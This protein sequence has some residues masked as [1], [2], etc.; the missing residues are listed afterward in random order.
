MDA[1]V[2][3]VT[4]KEVGTPP[5]DALTDLLDAAPDEPDAP[6]EPDAGPNRPE[7]E[8]DDGAPDRDGSADGSDAADGPRT[9]DH[10]QPFTSISMV[11]GLHAGAGTFDSAARLS[12]DELTV[13][14]TSTRS[15]AY[16]IWT[17]TRAS[18]TDDFLPP[19]RLSE[20]SSGTLDFNP[21]VTADGSTMYFESAR[22]GAFGIHTAKR[23]TPD[24][25]WTDQTVFAPLIHTTYG[26]GQPY[27][28]PQDDIIYFQ[29]NRTGPLRIYRVSR[30]LSGEWDT[31]ATVRASTDFEFSPVVSGDDLTLYFASDR[32]GMQ[33]AGDYDIWISTRRYPGVP[34]TEAK[35]VEGVN[36]ALGETPSWISPDGCRLYFARRIGNGND[37]R[38]YM[39]TR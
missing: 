33:A 8:P 24:G 36:T 10:A 31:P 4:A 2:D 6:I 9:C 27:V 19:T 7:V 16:E 1:P 26:D 30:S 5:T 37:S 13:Y 21:S 14:F 15:G 18:R 38:I 17:A 25:G 22:T 34:F 32:G 35:L 28:L 20:L 12:P 29:S 23:S 3:V 39:A 11:G